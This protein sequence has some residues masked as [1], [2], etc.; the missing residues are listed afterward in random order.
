MSA[1]RENLAIAAFVDEF[2]TD[3][4]AKQA[5]ERLTSLTSVLGAELCFITQSRQAANV[6]E[7][8]LAI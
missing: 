1:S 6:H 5:P 8:I 3:L 4:C 7:M 2:F